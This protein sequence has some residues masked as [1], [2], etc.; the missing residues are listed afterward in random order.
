MYCITIGGC[1]KCHCY[2]IVTETNAPWFVSNAIIRNDLR[3]T[4]IH[5][6]VN[7]TLQHLPAAAHCASQPPVNHPTPS[8]TLQQKT[9]RA[10]SWRPGH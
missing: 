6:E 7:K 2:G 9:Q 5:Q 3:V 1:N 8:A 4:T 10:L